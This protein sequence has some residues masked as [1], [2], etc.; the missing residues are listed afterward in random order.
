[1]QGIELKTKVDDF[2]A[3]RVREIIEGGMFKNEEDFLR[4]AIKEMVKRYQVQELNVKM[5]RFAKVMARKHPGSLSETVLAV[6]T[7]EN[8]T[9]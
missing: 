4:N 1:M 3:R 5:D 2:L 8:E 9:L 6:R 7:E